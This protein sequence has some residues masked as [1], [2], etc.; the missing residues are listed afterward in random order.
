MIECGLIEKIVSGDDSDPKARIARAAI[1]E[2]ALRSLDGARIR[3]IAKISGT[4]VAAISYHFGGKEGLYNAVVAGMS[5]Y[6]D[7][8]VGP[9]YEEGAEICAAENCAAARALAIRFLIDAIRKFSTVKIVPTLCLM[10]SREAASPS[11]YFQRVYGSIYE[12]PVEFLARLFITASGG[13]TE[14]GEAVV[15]AQALWSNVRIYSSKSE[16]ILRLHGWRDMGEPE[17]SLLEKS[18]SKVLEKT[19]K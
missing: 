6:F 9:Y 10:M 14:H 1:G 19:L 12:K 13:R 4:N 5:D 15:F 11:E 7:K 18:L 17:I 8:I 2:F 3:E 16:A